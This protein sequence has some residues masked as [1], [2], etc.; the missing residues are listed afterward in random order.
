MLVGESEYYCPIGQVIVALIGVERKL[1]TVSLKPVPSFGSRNDSTCRLTAQSEPTQEERG[2]ARQV[3]PATL[4]LL[5]IQPEPRGPLHVVIIR[6]R[7]LYGEV[8]PV[9][10]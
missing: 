9:G 2:G 1:V 5:A 3:V 8:A 10:A 7:V 6:T 4:E